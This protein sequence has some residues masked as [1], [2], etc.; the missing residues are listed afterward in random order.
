MTSK[1]DTSRQPDRSATGS[2]AAE[3]TPGDDGWVMRPKVK[4]PAIRNRRASEGKKRAADIASPDV[5]RGGA[6]NMTLEPEE[7]RRSRRT[8]ALFLAGLVY[9]AGVAG[10]WSIYQTFDQRDQPSLAPAVDEAT[11]PPP[12]DDTID[13]RDPLEDE[14][15][16][17]PDLKPDPDEVEEADAELQQA[18]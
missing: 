7:D 3:A 10:V 13:V 12:I 18:G 1:P 14:E 4:A 17:R 9:L 11:I 16:I 8:L 15:L 2:V 6:M 5:I